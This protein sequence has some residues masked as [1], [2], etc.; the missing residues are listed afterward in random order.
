MATVLASIHSS[1]DEIVVPRVAWRLHPAGVSAGGADHSNPHRGIHRSGLGI[2]V[3]GDDRIQRVRVVDQRKDA[4]AGRVELPVRDA[5]AIR[6]PAETIADAQFFLVHPVGRAVDRRLRPVARELS[7]RPVVQALDVDIVGA[8]VCDPRAVR[9][10]LREHQ[11]RLRS[12]PADLLAARRCPPPA[13]S[14]RR[15]CSAATLS[16]CS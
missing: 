16:S 13:P 6:A 9:R 8:D 4:D 10:E 2:R 14:S 11:R 7:D 3:A 15:A 5:P 1:R 12:R